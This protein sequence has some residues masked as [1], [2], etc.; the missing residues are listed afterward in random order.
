LTANASGGSGTYTYSGTSNPAGFN[1]TEANPTV[2]PTTTT[3]YSL[4]VN[5]GSNTVTGSVTVTV[6]PLPTVLVDS[7]EICASVGSATITATPGSAGSYQYTWSVPASAANPG[8]VASFN[9]SVAG[10]YSVVITDANLCT[11]T[12]H[13]TLI[14]NPNPT[15]SVNSPAICAG[16]GQATITATPSPAGTYTYNWT[17]PGGM[18]NPGNVSSFT[19]DVAGVYSVEITDG[20]SCKATGTGTLTVHPVPTV[21]VSSVE[22]CAS[23]GVASISATPSP[24]GTYTYVWTVPAGV[25]NPGNVSG[26]NTAIDGTYSV[27]ITNNN[28]CTASGSG[29]VTINANPTVTVNS[30]VICASIGSTTITASPM[31]ASGTYHYTWTVPSGALNPGDVASFTA[32]VPGTYSVSIYDGKNCTASASGTLTIHANPIVTVN[33]PSLCPDGSTAEI[34]A[35]PSPA[36]GSIHTRG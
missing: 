31:P 3:V 18:T 5:D 27:T 2:N 26:F 8:N 19:T 16:S 36:S 28:G 9:A 35:T 7:P 10:S 13:G 34:K 25:T 22:I 33:S 32:S 30:P 11:G 14:I 21:T 15:V 20:E 1:S 29:T 17:V 23:E 4:T 6:Y 24:A 12:G